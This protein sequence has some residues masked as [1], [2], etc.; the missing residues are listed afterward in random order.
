MTAITI[1]IETTHNRRRP[2]LAE[3]VEELVLPAGVD[4]LHAEPSADY[5]SPVYDVNQTA[6]MVHAPVAVVVSCHKEYLTMLPKAI[7][8]VNAQTCAPAEKILAYDGPAVD[9]TDAGMTGFTRKDI[10]G[11]HIIAGK[12]GSPN[13]GRNAAIEHLDSPWVIFAD[14][15][16]EMDKDYVRHCLAVACDAP[17]TVGI[18][19][20][21]IQ[22][23]DGRQ[24]IAPAMFDYWGLRQRNYISAASCWRVAAIQEAGGWPLDTKCYD[25]YSLALNITKL[26]WQCRKGLGV[27]QV[28]CHDT[29]HRRFTGGDNRHVP[30]IWNHRSYAIVTLFSGRSKRNARNWSKW[31]TFAEIPPNTTLY[32]LNN[33]GKEYILPPKARIKNVVVI[34]YPKG[35]P[36]GGDRYDR[37]RFVAHLYNQ[38]LPRARE[39]FVVFLEDDMVPPLDGLRKLAEAWNYRQRHAAIGGVYLSRYNAENPGGFV[40]ASRGQDYW[41]IDVTLPQVQ[42]DKLYEF[43]QI[44]GGFTLWNNGYLQKCL[45]CRFDY[46]NGSIPNGWDTNL[47]MATRNLGGRLFLHGGVQC[48]HNYE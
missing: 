12:S 13:P 18:V 36:E 39:D 1:E 28:N 45:P 41:S 34:D 29:G 37:H 43:P 42:E 38:I 46:Y 33:S 15:D 25:D 5:A 31:L 44:A 3:V 14:A 4:V 10:E 32:V 2:T 22:Y 19:Y 6:A 9:L 47:S 24:L 30:H 48:E 11:W 27:I 40:V 23:S 8:A 17:N 35:F 16:D 26:G 7:A 20:N 21:D